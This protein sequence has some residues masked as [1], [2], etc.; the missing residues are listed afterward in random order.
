MTSIPPEFTPPLGVPIHTPPQGAVCVKTN[1]GP[2]WKWLV[3]AV[4]GSIMS[5][6]VA[7]GGVYMKSREELIRL[8]ERF[9]GYKRKSDYRDDLQGDLNGR[10]DE[11]LKE[12]R[13]ERRTMNENII[14]IGERLRMHRDA[15][16][17][18]GEPHDY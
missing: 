3:G 5:A 7:G 14:R 1:N 9:E 15:L 17:P 16:K 2:T 18:L 6:T 11:E 4:A 8:E 13:K 10:F 12:A